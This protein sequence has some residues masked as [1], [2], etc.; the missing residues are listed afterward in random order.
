ML[1]GC[2]YAGVRRRFTAQICR[3]GAESGGGIRIAVETSPG[4]SFRPDPERSNAMKNLMSVAKRF[5]ESEDGPTAT[6]DAVML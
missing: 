2:A 3:R 1:Q 5:L 6:E 4:C